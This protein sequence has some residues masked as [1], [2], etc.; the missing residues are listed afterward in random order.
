MVIINSV[1]ASPLGDNRRQGCR[2]NTLPEALM[3]IKI[4]PCLQDSGGITARR[5]AEGRLVKM[6]FKTFRK[7]HRR[8]MMETQTAKNDIF[9][10]PQIPSLHSAPFCVSPHYPFSLTSAPCWL[11]SAIAS[12]PCG[13][14]NQFSSFT[15]PLC[16]HRAF[17]NFRQK[18]ADMRGWMSPLSLMAYRSWRDH[19][20]S[21]RS[22]TR[23]FA[24]SMAHSAALSKWV[25]HP[26]S[27]SC[28]LCC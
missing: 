26:L 2:W 6:N 27:Q 12:S 18:H 25:Y 3:S 5:T 11:F 8:P 20:Q 19:K 17:L 13:L 4:K 1:T 22:H 14:Q 16:P 10:S 28:A 23:C 7:G 21:Q 9:S 24:C 15:F